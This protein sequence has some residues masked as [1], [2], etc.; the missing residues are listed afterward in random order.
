MDLK[1]RISLK[2]YSFGTAIGTGFALYSGEG[3]LV[4]TVALVNII[5]ASVL[6]H[7][8]WFALLG[9]MV[10]KLSSPTKDKVGRL[11]FILQILGKWLVLG[12]SF[13]LA[14]QYARDKI[15]HA[16]ILF[17]FQ[18]IILVLSIKNISSYFEKGSS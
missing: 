11:G 16:L 8:L 6:N 14:S 9:K 1:N 10:R 7:Y 18:L 2:K 13:Y 5:A 4:K 15:A 17:T 12:L 3:D